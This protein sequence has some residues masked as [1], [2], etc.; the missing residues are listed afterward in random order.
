MQVYHAGDPF[1]YDPEARIPFVSIPATRAKEDIPRLFL[2]D[3]SN[4]P[5]DRVRLLLRGR[6]PD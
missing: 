1:L 3:S 4:F 2:E 6:S 5:Y